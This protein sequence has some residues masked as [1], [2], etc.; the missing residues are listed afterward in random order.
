MAATEKG[1]AIMKGSLSTRELLAAVALTTSN[2]RTKFRISHA[3]VMDIP[4]YHKPLMITDAAILCKM[5]ERGQIIDGIL[6]GPLA[7]LYVLR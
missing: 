4:S 2:L 7:Y 5:A 1:D 3:Y 6:D